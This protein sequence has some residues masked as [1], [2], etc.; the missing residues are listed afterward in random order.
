MASTSMAALA[1]VREFINPT[2]EP[3]VK[4]RAVLEALD[5]LAQALA[6]REGQIAVAPFLCPNCG[7]WSR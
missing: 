5:T 6:E 1:T 2:R 7:C 4:M 3:L